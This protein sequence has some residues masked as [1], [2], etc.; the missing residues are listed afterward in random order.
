MKKEKTMPEERR[1]GKF[2]QKR[3]KAGREDMRVGCEDMRV[4]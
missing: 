3:R 2:K 1:E 4:G